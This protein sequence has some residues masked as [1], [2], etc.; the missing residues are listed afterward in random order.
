MTSRTDK[1]APLLRDTIIGLFFSSLCASCASSPRAAPYNPWLDYNMSTFHAVECRDGDADSCTILHT[2]CMTHGDEHSCSHLTRVD[3]EVLAKAPETLGDPLEYAAHLCSERSKQ[4]WCEHAE[5]VRTDRACTRGDTGACVTLHSACTTDND[6]HSCILL[7]KS[8]AD[9]AAIPQAFDYPSQYAAYLCIEYSRDHWCDH[10]TESGDW[11]DVAVEWSDDELRAMNPPEKPRKTRKKRKGKEASTSILSDNSAFGEDF[12][13][14]S[15]AMASSDWAYDTKLEEQCEAG[16]PM[17]CS[18][19]VKRRSRQQRGLKC[20]IG[21]ESYYEP[22]KKAD[23]RAH[24]LFF[25]KCLADDRISCMRTSAWRR[26]PS[27]RRDKSEDEARDA[28]EHKIAGYK[29]ACSLG[30]LHGCNATVSYI[31]RYQDTL[32]VN[33]SSAFAQE[34][35]DA[36]KRACTLTEKPESPECLGHVARLAL[37]ANSDERAGARARADALGLNTSYSRL[38]YWEHPAFTPTR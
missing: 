34:L 18:T 13:S 30:V 14:A 19:F 28:V 11:E 31:L 32:I 16:E 10:V 33:A 24:A 15:V 29:R 21:C 23:Q 27:P 5:T 2:S 38:A 3:R 22:L 12:A 17:A 35:A 26:D 4:E 25:K 36:S 37:G 1:R 20:G 9:L 7:T 8:N 6:F